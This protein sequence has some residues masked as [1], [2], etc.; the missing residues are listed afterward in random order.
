MLSP[1]VTP[2]NSQVSR[3]KT[4]PERKVGT[5]SNYMART[6][7]R[8]LSSGQVIRGEVTDLRN[9]EI[10]ITME[11]NTIVTGH[12][13][14]GSN[15]SIGETA[16]FLITDI[17]PDRISLELLQNSLQS[18]ERLTI[19]KALEEAGLPI[20]E[21]NQSIVRELLANKMP[22]HK[23]SIMNILTQSYQF[24]DISIPTLVAMNHLGMEI[25]ED[26]AAQFEN[27]CTHASTITGDAAIL[28]TALVSC[29][30][31][32]SSQ[33]SAEFI[34][35]L[36]KMITF[37]EPEETTETPKDSSQ[38]TSAPPEST[39]PPVQTAPSSLLPG[40]LSNIFGFH[41]LT[42]LLSG[43]REISKGQAESPQQPSTSPGTV[44]LS[45]KNELSSSISVFTETQKKVLEDLGK[46]E[47]PVNPMAFYQK[48]AEI[49]EEL[50]SLIN[51]LDQLTEKASSMLASDPMLLRNAITLFQEA[52]HLADDID[53]FQINETRKHFLE[54]H[55]EFP[56][57][58]EKSPE[59][60]ECEQLSQQ[61]E[62]ALEKVPSCS[63]LLPS[64][65]GERMENEYSRYLMD[66]G[67]IASILKP[68][69][70]SELNTKA[71][72]F[73]FRPEMQSR[74][75]D[76]DVSLKEF[77]T[78][79]RNTSSLVPDSVI[80]S[81]ASTD[82]FGKL[83]EQ[84]FL[85]SFSLTPKELSKPDKLEEFYDKT[86]ERLKELSNAISDFKASSDSS[87]TLDLANQKSETMQKQLEFLKSLN[88]L[89]TYV[90]IPVKLKNGIQHSDLYVYTKKESLREDPKRLS[91]LL[92]LDMD[93]LGPLDI[94]LSLNHANVTSKI[95]CENT[96]IKKFLSAQIPSLKTAL[97]LK[98]YL[99]EAE[100][101][102]REKPF[103]FV[104]D[105]IQKE[106]Q[107]TMPK[108]K[109]AMKRYTFDI[110][111]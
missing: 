89:Y 37:S 50:Q 2:T 96:E 79:L 83:F 69:E 5:M 93:N 54:K 38:P 102:E 58:L 51:R 14:E 101:S 12:L 56:E 80:Q 95:Y 23:Q 47:K 70:L 62:K 105:F 36:L 91:V 25:T 109:Q 19:H 81:M 39:P 76:G 35:Q 88:E 99:F 49:S 97:N 90:Q 92:H 87:G 46:P 10:T 44:S 17:Q 9:T 29:L 103:D 8:S 64:A 7:A 40:G 13:Q 60:P 100:I 71:A 74:L 26:S 108:N 6:P 68:E 94:H 110:R 27:C 43:Q 111:A 75:K 104:K 78:V 18:S 15:L 85:S 21:K 30:K 55:P 67:T 4:Q 106:E 53:F 59:S 32:T 42:G 57:L 45:D 63:A 48:P 82:A 73:P 34:R 107:R 61:L 86:Y 33:Q 3:S 41:R 20:N 98:G 52:V 31:E 77:L 1:G 16:A 72:N 65:L 24:K 28:T 66:K 84:A 11:N 22:I